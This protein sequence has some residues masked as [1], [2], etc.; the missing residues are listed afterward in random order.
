MLSS[1]WMV[2]TGFAANIVLTR[3]LAPEVFGTFALAMFFAQLLRLQPKLGLGYAFVQQ[4]A[5]TGEVLGTY[6]GLDVLGIGASVLLTLLAAPV[7]LWTGQPEVVVV[8]CLAL[9]VAV[10]CESLA[11]MS[12]LL[13]EREMLFRQ[14]SMLQSMLFPLAYLPA[15]A[16]AWHSGSVWSLVLHYGLYYGLL[17]VGVVWIISVRLPHIRQVRWRFDR[18]LARHLLRFGVTMG[19]GVL[20]AGLLVQLDNFSLVALWD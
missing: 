17:C 16:L 12:M 13:L 8:V 14:T 15:I 1:Y 20:A 19:I 6:V 11:S 2:G 18:N 3:L 10:A 4:K 9:G 7:L 5:W